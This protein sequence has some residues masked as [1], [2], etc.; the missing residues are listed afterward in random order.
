MT[1]TK[2]KYGEG[3]ASF[4]AAGQEAGLRKLVN[5]FYEVMSEE[6]FAKKIRDMHPKNITVSAD[7][8]TLFLCGWLGGPKLFREKYGSI[9]IPMAHSHL[10]I[11]P[12][13]RD[14]WLKCME[15]ALETQP[16]EPEFKAYLL[17]ELT[18]PATRSQNRET[19][20]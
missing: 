10:A 14:A 2:P 17:R 7:K 6:G 15:L 12:D 5:R 11:G 16:Y 13:E 20:D 18:V 4:Q 8:L 19:S 1:T 9:R 3:D